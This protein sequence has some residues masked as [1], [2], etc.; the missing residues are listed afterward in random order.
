MGGVVG[1]GVDATGLPVEADAQVA[2]GC[3]LLHDRDLFAG[4]WVG[5]PF[6][7]RMHV[8]IAIRTILGALATA[9]APVLDDDLPRVAPANRADGAADHAVGIETGP[10]RAGYEGF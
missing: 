5:P 4:L 1:A 7:E 3:F 2:H 8:D 9:D 10:S 6:L